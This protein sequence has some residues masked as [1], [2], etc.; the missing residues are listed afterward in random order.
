MKKILAGLLLFSAGMTHAQTSKPYDMV[1]NGVK[2]IVV[3]SGNEIVQIDLVQKGG[4]Q[5]YSADKAGIENLAFRALTECGTLKDDKNSFKNKLDE[6]D[7][8]IYGMAGRDASHFQLNC[9]KGDF[10]TVWPLY[11]DALTI[12]KFDAKEFA[13][14]KEESI[15]NLRQLESNP[16]QAL[17]R[18]A[19]ETAF[20]GMD[21]AKSAN[22]TIA[23][24][25]KLT[26][27]ETKAYLK[28]TLTRSRI[29]VV[30]V[31]DLSK[32]DI[33]KKM[34][35]LLSKIPQGKP[36][37]LKRTTYVPKANTF[38][39]AQKDVATNY[40]MGITAA[41][42]ALS[43][44]YYAGTLASRLFY[45]KTFLEVR[46]NNGLSYAPAASISSNLTPFSMLYV[47]TKEPDKYIAVVRNLVDKIKKEGFKEDDVQNTKNTYA[48]GQYYNSEAN[49]SLCAMVANTE[50][51]LGDWRHAFTLKEDLKNVTPADVSQVF[52]KYIGNFTW[53][54]Q[55]DP[56]KVTTTLFT[57]K[58]T[59]P[60]PKDT[61][62]F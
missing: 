31:A 28:N 4:V 36:F 12:P 17:Q 19:M 39:P 35:A 56:K 41:P 40:I 25:E 15:N 20:K 1:V 60:I 23:N 58:E 14:I 32:E 49:E 6:V 29:Y 52:N 10:E 9:I 46:T 13:R 27:A 48:T 59:P 22:G 47:T 62:A 8:R 54:Y 26:A 42:S 37:T 5:N 11:V 45:D 33:Q 53:V 30:V 24:I 57:Q 51:R 2:V 3:P 38:V 61:K 16:D 55:G 21:Y 50:L 18:M 7:A 44:D 43:P 34:T